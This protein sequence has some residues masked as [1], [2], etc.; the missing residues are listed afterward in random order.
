MFRLKD[1]EGER[2]LLDYVFET[3]EALRQM[4]A[5]ADK[6]AAE[7]QQATAAPPRRV[8]VRAALGGRG[9]S[10]PS[11]PR[12]RP[13]LTSSSQPDQVLLGWSD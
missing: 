1:D 8:R 4:W 5:A 2:V 10:V 3:H 13:P 9:W 7:S 12:G 6:R 11:Q